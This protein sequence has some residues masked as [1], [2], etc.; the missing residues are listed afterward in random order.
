MESRHL[1]G[2]VKNDSSIQSMAQVPIKRTYEGQTSKSVQCIRVSKL[3]GIL[4]QVNHFYRFATHLLVPF[5]SV[6]SRTIR[7]TENSKGRVFLTKFDRY[8]NG[9]TDGSW[10]LSA[11]QIG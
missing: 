2:T 1:G 8:A 9:A 10:T 3:G 11:G 4:E 7:P 5:P 6:C